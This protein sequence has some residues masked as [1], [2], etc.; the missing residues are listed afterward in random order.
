[1]NI[2]NNFEM[3]MVKQLLLLFRNVSLKILRIKIHSGTFQTTLEASLSR[4]SSQ[5]EQLFPLSCITWVEIICG[6]IVMFPVQA[7]G[8]TA[9]V[10]VEKKTTEGY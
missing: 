5:W 10:H 4:S 8:K 9:Q 6:C 7:V 2:E 1:M 3:V